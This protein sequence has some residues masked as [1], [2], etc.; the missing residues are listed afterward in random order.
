MLKQLQTE[1]GEQLTGEAL[2]DAVSRLRGEAWEAGRNEGYQEGY[3]T[4][5]D[6]QSRAFSAALAL[7]LHN[8]LGFDREQIM[9]VQNACNREVSRLDDALIEETLREY[10]TEVRYEGKDDFDVGAGSEEGDTDA[11]PQA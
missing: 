7:A 8:D 10:L 4:A 5:E 11:E 6:E 2:V 1:T 3:Q 9:A